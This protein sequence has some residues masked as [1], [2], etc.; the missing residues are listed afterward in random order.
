[1]IAP[2]QHKAL[3]VLS[4]LDNPEKDKALKNFDWIYFKNNFI[5]ETNYRKDLILYVAFDWEITPEGYNY[6][7]ETQSKYSLIFG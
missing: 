3:K 5:N 4:S 1:M 2:S 7:S 6:W